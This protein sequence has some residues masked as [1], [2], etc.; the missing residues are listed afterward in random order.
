MTPI[1]IVF[2]AWAAQP[3]N[4]AASAHTAASSLSI[5]VPSLRG[6]DRAVAARLVANRPAVT[7]WAEVGGGTRRGQRP[8]RPSVDLLVGIDAPQPVLLDPAVEPVAGEAAPRAGALLDLA[9]DARLQTGHGMGVIVGAVEQR[10]EVVLDLL[11]G[12]HHR[13][14]PAGQEGVI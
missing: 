7:R 5:P 6:A 4:P 1:L 2:W 10:H 14:A 8:H 12:D 9:V 13:G 3:P 11:V